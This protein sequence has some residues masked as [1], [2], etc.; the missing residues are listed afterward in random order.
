MTRSLLIK[1]GSNWEANA[2]NPKNWGGVFVEMTY[3][4]R[5]HHIGYSVFVTEG[6]VAL[7][8][9]YFALEDHPAE[10]ALRLACELRDNLKGR[11]R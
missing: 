3:N 1:G 8:K 6:A 10:T 5:G 2:L 9:R 11:K 7:R 4:E